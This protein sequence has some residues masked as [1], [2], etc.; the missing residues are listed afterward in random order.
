MNHDSDPRPQLRHAGLHLQEANDRAATPPWY[1]LTL[2]GLGGWLSALFLMVFVGFSSLSLLT[3][4]PVSLIL[5]ASLIGGAYKL[6]RAQN[7]VFAE[8]LILASSLTGQLLVAYSIGQ[9]LDG[10]N[11]GFWLCL[12]ALHTAL[13]FYMANHLH[14]IFSSLFAALSLFFFAGHTG[15]TYLVP[16]LCLALANDEVRHRSTG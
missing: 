2:Q 15:L 12:F 9:L 14:Q 3:F 7:S 13:A 4:T 5:G 1:L 11:A 16:P 8:Q 6:L 10:A